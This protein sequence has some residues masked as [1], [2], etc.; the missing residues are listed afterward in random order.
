MFKPSNITKKPGGCVLHTLK[1]IQLVTRQSK[2]DT[3]AIVKAAGDECIY[4]SLRTIRTKELPYSSNVIQMKE[5][6]LTDTIY[7]L[8]HL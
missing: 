5:G 7:V 4:Q 2:Q 3:T 6:G 1:L 8:I